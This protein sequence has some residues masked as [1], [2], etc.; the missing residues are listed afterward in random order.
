V[1]ERPILFSGEMVRAILD[2]R[3]TQTRRVMKSQPSPN[4][5]DMMMWRKGH[6][7]MEHGSPLQKSLCP[8]GQVGDRLWVREAW[9]VEGKHTDSYSSANIGANR[10]HFGR[11]DYEA[12]IIWDKSIYGKLRPGIFMSRWASRITLEITGVRVERLQEIAL[13]DIVSEGIVLDKKDFPLWPKVE[14]MGDALIGHYTPFARQAMQNVWDSI[15]ARR[16]FG[17]DANPLVWV[18]EFKAVQP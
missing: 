13:R 17:W 16:G 4:S 11:I 15:N 14:V 1:K 2:G 6:Q 12:S 5:H 8:Y 7:W 18:I 9:R 10:V 3:K